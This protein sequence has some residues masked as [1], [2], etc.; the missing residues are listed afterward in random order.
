MTF[1]TL[2]MRRLTWR[3]CREAHVHTHTHAHTHTHTHSLSCSKVTLMEDRES[4]IHLRNLSLHPT[5]NEEE[6]G[7][8]LSHWWAGLIGVGGCGL[9]SAALNWLFLGDTNRMM[10]EV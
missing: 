2:D 9:F 7:C 1:L 4:V 6:G 3:T 10:A 5:N 8:G